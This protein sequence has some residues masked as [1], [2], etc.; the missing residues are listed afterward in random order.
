MMKEAMVDSM[1]TGCVQARKA[2]YMRELQIKPFDG[3]DSRDQER[4]D[5][6]KEIFSRLQTRSLFKHI[7]QARMYKY[8]VID[9]E[10][11]VIDG[12]QV[13]TRYKF[14]D[15]KYFQYDTNGDGRLKID[16]NN[17]LEEIP[18]EVLVCESDD[19]PF[20]LPVL[21]DYILKEFGLEAWASFIETFGEGM[22]IGYYPPNS[23]QSVKDALDEAVNTIAAS[24]RG[25]APK[26]TD[27]EIKEANRSTGDHRDFKDASDEGISISILGHANAAKQSNTQIGQNESQF[28]PMQF[29]SIDDLYF[30]DECL[31]QMVKTIHDRN[32]GDS[33][34]P[35]V[36]TS[37]PDQVG[38]KERRENIRLW[39]NMGFTISPN[40]GRKLG[41]EV[42]PDDEPQQKTDPFQY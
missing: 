21:R 30:I 39:W 12:K 33:R 34:Y 13:P 11:A 24:S 2:G 25:T 22:I 28:K 17:N 31:D 16:I 1:V 6:Y 10:W 20:M 37:K 4:A 35:S 8:S 14:F 41:I 15:Q 42:D 29:I 38:M 3:E 18:P 27:I 5:L 40:E 7:M 32:F 23:S 19:T 36:L 9:F 26:G